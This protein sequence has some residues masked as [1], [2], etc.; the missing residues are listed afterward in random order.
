[1]LTPS[2]RGAVASIGVLGPAAIAAVARR[3]EP[4]SGKLLGEF[5][6]ASIVVGHFDAGT[7]PREELVV[8]IVDAERVE[9]HCHGGRA[10]VEAIVKS[11]VAD[12]CEL[13]P[14]EE[15]ENEDLGAIERDALVA[16]ASASTERTAGLLLAQYRGA[17]R[18]EIEK[19][20]AAVE[21]GDVA[22]AME[23]LDSLI[24]LAAIGTHLTTPWRVA[25][26]GRPNVGKSSLVNALLG[27]QRAIVFDQPG[28]TR[29]VLTASTAFD[30]WPVELVDMAGMRASDD[31]LEAAGIARAQ[32]AAA[33]ADCLLA[34][35]D[36]TKPWTAGD[37]QWLKELPAEPKRLILFNKVDLCSPPHDG[38]PAGITIS[39]KTGQGLEELAGAIVTAIAGDS[40]AGNVAMP[41]SRR[42]VQR[43][44]A[45]R[46]QI[47]AGNIAAAIDELRLL[48]A[49]K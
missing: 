25:L 13:I 48:L 47:A 19:I 6:P 45:C 26:A 27:Y 31:A 24:Q 49:Q 5:S 12:G 28:T 8:G 17:L 11:L 33:S 29:D 38:R 20:V 39:A 1:M 15:A 32:Q 7:G 44:S 16:L 14:W 43:L 22:L 21:A 46:Q 30:G 37:E 36:A 9:I 41:F 4:L 40:F 3:F 2:G 34:V 42:Q 18:K 35:F 23:S 10:A